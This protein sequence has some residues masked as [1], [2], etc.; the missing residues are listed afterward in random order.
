MKKMFS[1]VIVIV[2]L[3]LLLTGIA[4]ANEA[5][6]TPVSREAE[7]TTGETNNA[8]REEPI[9]EEP[10]AEEDYVGKDIEL[11]DG[12]MGITS[13]EESEEEYVG[14]DLELKEGE[15]G[16]VS[17]PAGS[18][19]DLARQSGIAEEE[20]VKSNFPLYGGILAAAAVAFIVYKKVLV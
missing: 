16:I 15:V 13:V 19:E 2:M 20:P 17:L 7:V 8:V 10:S 5:P 11:R 4:A 1:V 18:A 9:G 6:D 3:S 12:E 14:K